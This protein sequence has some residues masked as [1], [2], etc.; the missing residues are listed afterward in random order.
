MVAKLAKDIALK[1]SSTA[2]PKLVYGTAWKKERSADLVYTA[3]KHGFRGIDTAGQPKHYNEKGVG[4]GV[5][6]AIRDGI[7]KR[8]TLFVSFFAFHA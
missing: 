3:L 4:Q 1:G 5:Q 8:E 7:I 2:M 6:R